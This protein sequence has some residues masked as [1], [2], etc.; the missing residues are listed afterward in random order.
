[1][2]FSE[3]GPV[4]RAA[5]PSTRRAATSSSWSTSCPASTR[6]ANWRLQVS[7]G[8]TQA[9][10]VNRYRPSSVTANS[11]RQRSLPSGTIGDDVRLDGHLLARGSPG[12]KPPG[13][14]FGRDRLDG[15]P[16]PAIDVRLG[17][18]GG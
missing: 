6:L 5:V 4:A 17:E 18:A 1:M 9:S 3:S 13:V 2:S 15:D 8:S 7:K 11:A 10:I 12:R 14:D 16:S